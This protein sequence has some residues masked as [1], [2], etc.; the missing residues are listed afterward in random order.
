MKKWGYCQWMVVRGVRG[1]N[2]GSRNT[3]GLPQEC[4]R[5][6]YLFRSHI[7]KA[8]R[9]DTDQSLVPLN[10]T[11]AQILG[12]VVPGKTQTSYSISQL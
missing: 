1:G 4:C 12:P 7:H 2:E 6:W 11:T 3:P 5:Y 8:K 10:A 9:K